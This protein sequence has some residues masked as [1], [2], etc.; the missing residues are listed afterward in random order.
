METF[1]ISLSKDNANRREHISNEFKKK[2]IDFHF[3]D[4]I[5][6]SEIDDL[7]IKYEIDIKNTKLT[8]GELACLFSHISLW[9]KILN[10]NLKYAMIFEDDIYLS[11]ETEIFFNKIK[12]KNIQYDIIN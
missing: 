9:H 4:A 7:S 1:V 8:K 5:T 2:G 6:P 3:F 12:D 10:L 11:K